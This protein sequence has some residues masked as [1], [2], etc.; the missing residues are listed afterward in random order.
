MSAVKMARQLSEHTFSNAN[1]QT[2]SMFYGLTKSCATHTLKDDYELTSTVHQMMTS[3][4]QP[5][6]DS[7]TNS[8]MKF[9]TFS[10]VCV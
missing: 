3:R 1:N 9:S 4:N 6:A 2:Q 10:C 8:K 7:A 5:P